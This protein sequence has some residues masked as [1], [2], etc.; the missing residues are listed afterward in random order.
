MSIPG[1]NME[2]T[3]QVAIFSD[4]CKDIMIDT[5]TSRAVTFYK[6]DFISF[7][8]CCKKKKVIKGIAK[9]LKIEGSGTVKYQFNANDGSVI[10]LQCEAFYVS[11]MHMILLSPQDAGTSAGNPVKF[12][13]FSLF[14]GKKGYARLDAMPN[15]DGWED[16]PPVYTK[17]MDLHPRNN[18][19][20]LMIKTK[21]TMEENMIGLKAAVDLAAEKNQNLTSAQKEL[22]HWHQRLCHVSFL[23]IQWLARSGHLPVKNL[24]V[25]GK[26]QIPICASCQL[27]K[28]K[29]RP[30]KAT[31]SQQNPE[32]EGKL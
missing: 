22:L 9:G 13:T 1:I 18:L 5:G 32:K 12:S 21:K 15:A 31:K 6:D 3:K 29:R 8:C 7:K 23:T 20:W 27:A 25:V 28:Q 24:D 17:R 19:P 2:N 4:S 10:V 11:D 16:M 14:H 26:C 30:H